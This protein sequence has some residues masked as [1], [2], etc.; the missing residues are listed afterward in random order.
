MD[1]DCEHTR[2]YLVAKNE[3]CVAIHNR[4]PLKSNPGMLVEAAKSITY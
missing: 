1:C 2:V 4:D 3:N